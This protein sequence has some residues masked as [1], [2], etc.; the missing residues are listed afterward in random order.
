MANNPKCK[1]IEYE[2]DGG[3]IKWRLFRGPAEWL[4]QQAAKYR[5]PVEVGSSRNP[6]QVRVSVNKKERDE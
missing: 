2:E 3:K 5:E 4:E 6:A 1:V